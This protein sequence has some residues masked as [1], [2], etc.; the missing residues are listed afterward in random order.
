[1]C[2][3]YDRLIGKLIGILDLVTLPFHKREKFWIAGMFR[4]I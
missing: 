1:M 4:T 2:T 3:T